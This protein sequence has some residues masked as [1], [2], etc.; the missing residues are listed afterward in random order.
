MAITNLDILVANIQAP[1]IADGHGIGAIGTSSFGA[2]KTYRRTESGV[3]ITKILIDVTGLASVATGADAI[4][5]TAGAAYFGKNVVADNGIIFK[6]EWACL[7]TAAT[8][9][10]EVDVIINTSNTIIKGGALGA[11]I[12]SDSGDLLI[13]QSVIN[14]IPTMP[15]NYYYYM[16]SGATGDVA[17]TYSAGQFVFTTWG[18]AVLA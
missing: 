6:C 10:N 2:P 11:D 15:A 16:A 7:E 17:G 4:G 18:H 12:M 9:D 8:G 1:Q 13:G 5:L 3:I 14:L